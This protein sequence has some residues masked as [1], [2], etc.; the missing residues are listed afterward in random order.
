MQDH[1]T[2]NCN[3][4]HQLNSFD[5]KENHKSPETHTVKVIN[6]HSSCQALI[7]EKKATYVIKSVIYN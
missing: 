4:G 3:Q 6:M 7:I 5:L 1:M 2:I